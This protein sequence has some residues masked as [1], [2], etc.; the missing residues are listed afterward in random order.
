MIRS[1]QAVRNMNFPS[2]LESTLQFLNVVR[3]FNLLDR[4]MRHYERKM[5]GKSD[6]WIAKGTKNDRKKWMNKSFLLSFGTRN[7]STFD[8]VSSELTSHSRHCCSDAESNFHVPF[9]MVLWWKWVSLSELS[10]DGAV[11]YSYT[12]CR[13]FHC[14]LMLHFI[15]GWQYTRTHK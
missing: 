5:S 14:V 9:L 4:I 13:A 7:L 2:Y 11:I 6:E 1:H 12:V 10:A 15:T 8:S 3:I